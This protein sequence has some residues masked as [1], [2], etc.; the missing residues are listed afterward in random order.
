MKINLAN[1][2]TAELTDISQA[3]SILRKSKAKN[4]YFTLKNSRLF[5][6]QVAQFC[7]LT[8]VFIE[9][10]TNSEGTEIYRTAQ[11]NEDGAVVNFSPFIFKEQAQA[12]FN[13]LAQLP[14]LANNW[15]PAT[16]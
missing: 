11:I 8:G 12:N 3:R 9:V 6:T 7:P 2:Q 10:F 4:E 16:R 5:P 14:T 1:G 13:T 15:K